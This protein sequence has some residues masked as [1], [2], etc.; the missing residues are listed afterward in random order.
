V[1]SLDYL[2]QRAIM[3][4]QTERRASKMKKVIEAT[5]L[6]K[7]YTI[8][9]WTNKKGKLHRI[10]GPAFINSHGRKEWMRNDRPH[11]WIGPAVVTADG[12][13]E[14]WVN[15]KFIKSNES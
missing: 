10:W 12:L 3:A 6:G 1:I 15:G 8:T 13:K 14:W 7:I 9:M 11:R 4:T 2:I 5:A